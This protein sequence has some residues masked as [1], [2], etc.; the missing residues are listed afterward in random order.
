MGSHFLD[1]FFGGERN[2]GG[3]HA[4]DH[5]G[6]RYGGHRAGGNRSHE[7]ARGPWSSPDSSEQAAPARILVCPGCRTD[8]AADARYCARC[9]VR[10]G[11]AESSCSKCGASIRPDAKFCAACGQATAAAGGS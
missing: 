7:P 9:G 6:D 8:N 1:R 3:H 4:G 10:F 11:R 2:S 5:H